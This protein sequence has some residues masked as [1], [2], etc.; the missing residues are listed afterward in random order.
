MPVIRNS[1]RAFIA[2]LIVLV[3]FHGI[4]SVLGLGVFLANK[5]EPPSP[6]RAFQIFVT[7]VAVDAVLLAAGHWL[8]RSFGLATRM[9]Y[10]LMGGAAAA[11]G[12]AFALSQ[13]LNIAPAL[14]GTHLTASILPI[15]VGM[16]SATLYAQF[17][18]R[19]MLRG[20]H[21]DTAIADAALTPA[22]PANFDGPVQVRT[23]MAATAI[24]SM[25]PA[26]LV[27]LITI[28]FVTFFL[29]QWDTGGSQ[30]PA[31]ANQISQ[32]ALPA[33]F[34]MA[35]LLATAIPSAIIVSVTHAAARA[36]RRTAGMDYAIIG[37]VV[38][39]IACV[40]L[41][42][43]FPTPLLALVVVAAAIM[44]AAYRR[45]AG[46]EPLALP[47]AVLATDP[48]ALVGEHDAARRT[49]AVI[50]NG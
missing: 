11:V 7:R 33:Y 49:R 44:G 29:T 19:E 5:L 8:L 43:L 39:V 31:W 25:V 50:M 30:N 27:A 13:D 38:G 35:T 14:D 21:G 24:A 34:F 2:A 22:I 9:V 12:Y 4:M 1:A 40:A 32:M 17:A 45:F 18:G 15:I 3:I 23:S 47:E 41:L 26:A 48:A 28:P 20:R 42:M 37:A 16:I 6:D 10:G 46:I 36:F